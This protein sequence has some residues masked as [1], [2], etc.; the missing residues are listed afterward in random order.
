MILHISNSFTWIRRHYWVTC[1]EFNRRKS[2]FIYFLKPMPI[3]LLHSGQT[4]HST[5]MNAKANMFLFMYFME[6]DNVKLDRLTKSVH[7]YIFTSYTILVGRKVLP[8]A[9]SFCTI[10]CFTG[11]ITPFI[12]IYLSVIAEPAHYVSCECRTC[13]NKTL[14]HEH[15][16]IREETLMDVLNI[17][18]KRIL[19]D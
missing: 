16:G 8:N 14:K 17:W 1:L 4:L 2:G 10:Y 13:L 19:R 5:Q 3:F 18:H 9:S 11:N 15:A 7:Y 6:D 12:F